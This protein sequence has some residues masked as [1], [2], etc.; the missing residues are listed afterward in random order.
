VFRPRLLILDTLADFF[1]GDYLNTAHVRQFI[2]TGLGGLCVRHGCAVLLVAHPSAAGRSSGE[3][4]GFSTAWSNSVR[5]RLYLRR[6][7]SDDPEEVKDRRILEVRKSNYAA[8]GVS[9]PVIWHQGAFVPDS[10]P[11]SEGAASK[12]AP[13]VDTRLAVAAFEY[14]QNKAPDGSVVAFSALFEAL[15]VSG[16]L[17]KGHYET[18]RKPLQR[19]LRELEGAGRIVASK[20][21]RGY[22]L[23]ENNPDGLGTLG[24][25]PG[26]NSGSRDARDTGQP[27]HPLKG[28]VSPARPSP[29]SPSRQEGE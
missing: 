6:P 26:T 23:S 16:V 5:S 22:R 2:K 21:P 8:T 28:G 27:G 14:F 12:R 4:D 10:E 9:L 29:L 17:P 3:G 13:K 18:V 20:T 19:A 1:A 7:R 25:R 24:T 11:V 15:Q